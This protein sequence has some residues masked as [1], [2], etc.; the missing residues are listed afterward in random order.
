MKIRTYAAG[1]SAAL[2]TLIV[3]HNAPAQTTEATCDENC[4]CGSKAPIGVMGDHMHKEG[5]WMFSYRLMYMNMEDARSGTDNLSAQDVFD[6]GYSMSPAEMQMEMHMLG[7]MYAPSD[8]VTLMLMANYVRK[9][10][11]MVTSGGHGMDHGGM[12]HAMTGHESM[13][14]NHDMDTGHGRTALLINEFCRYG[15]R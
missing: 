7:T 10:M 8:D 15:L 5:E 12:M 9:D 3:S 1:L 14:M 4:T 2:L 11:E 13:E 6:M